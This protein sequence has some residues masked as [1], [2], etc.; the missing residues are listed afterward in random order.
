MNN[1]IR[2]F[3]RLGYVDIFL[4]MA[5][6][7]YMEYKQTKAK[8]DII[9]SVGEVY[10]KEGISSYYMM[11]NYTKHD[12]DLNKIT[13]KI[14]IFLCAYLEAYINDF[15]GIIFGDKK[16][17]DDLEKLDLVNK[18]IEIPKLFTGKQ[19]DKSKSYFEKLKELVKWRN[20]IVH[21]KSKDYTDSID[22]NELDIRAIYDIVDVSAYFKMLR[23]LFVDLDSIDKAGYHLKRLEM[24]L[25]KIEKDKRNNIKI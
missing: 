14:I 11:T 19:I 21:S 22:N 23:A 1:D 24:Y 9:K 16:R 2:T 3:S 7:G 6:D 4:D 5:I 18:W 15:A 17:E 20:F 25:G 12:Y 8:L 10:D 13:I